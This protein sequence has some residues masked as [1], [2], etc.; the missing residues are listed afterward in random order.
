MP[1]MLSKLPALN[2]DHISEETLDGP[3]EFKP[4][5]LQATPRSIRGKYKKIDLFIRADTPRE[6]LYL[7]VEN[8]EE[9]P[10]A[11]I[12]R[13]VELL[14]YIKTGSNAE[15]LDNY[16][17]AQYKLN[18]QPVS[19]TDVENNMRASAGARERCSGY[20]VDVDGTLVGAYGLDK[21]LLSRLLKITTDGGKVTI[22]SGGNSREQTERLRKLGVPE[23]LLPIVS[24]A[25]FQGKI[26]EHL[27]D[28]TPPDFQGFKAENVELVDKY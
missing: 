12:M 6:Y 4:A 7:L 19:L 2:V 9:I 21:G 18:E 5:S 15:I 22:F 27:I 25:D 28:D 13:A 1:R 3:F 14:E 10:G 24:K 23:N 20:Y 17:R 11:D 26:L 16:M 8:Q